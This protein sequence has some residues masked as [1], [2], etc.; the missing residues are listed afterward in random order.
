MNIAKR[1]LI[2]IGAVLTLICAFICLTLSV[3]LF[4]FTTDGLLNSIQQQRSATF[5]V[6]ADGGVETSPDAK[7]VAQTLKQTFA[8]SNKN[9]LK[10]AEIIA[11]DGKVAVY[12]TN[13][14]GF[15]DVFN[16]LT[17]PASIIITSSEDMGENYGGITINKTT[18]K[19]ISCYANKTT[20]T[21]GIKI[22]L[23]ELVLSNSVLFQTQTKHFIF[24]LMIKILCRWHIL[25]MLKT[26]LMGTSI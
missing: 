1:K 5:T 17:K 11:L 19:S 26:E 15:A 14:F 21:Y 9:E 12:M 23:N 10:N 4:A 6:A 20:K 3:V 22:S 16:S 8:N 25:L 13:T 24:M 2:K 7:E 18:F